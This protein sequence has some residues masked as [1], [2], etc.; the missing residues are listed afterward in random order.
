MA[1]AK[2]ISSNRRSI[3]ITGISVVISARWILRFSVVFFFFFLK[4]LI[5]F[6]FSVINMSLYVCKT[7]FSNNFKVI[8]L[9]TEKIR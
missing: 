2:V 4:K 9:A 7:N 6:K 5:T 3:T 8:Y 1:I